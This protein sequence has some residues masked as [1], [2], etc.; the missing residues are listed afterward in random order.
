MKKLPIIA[1]VVLMSSLLALPALAKNAEEKPIEGIED[2]DRKQ[3][4]A[5]FEAQES[6]DLGNYYAAANAVRVF[7]E[8]EPG[9]DHYLL[10]FALASD[11]S[12]AEKD[13]DAA[14]NYKRCVELEPRFAQGWLNLGELAYNLEDYALAAEA[15]ENGYNLH[16]ERPPRLLYYAA[17]AHVLN[18]D[19][20]SAIPALEHLTSGQA[21]EPE[22]DWFRALV[23]AAIELDDSE[24]GERAI[25]NLLKAHGATA[26]A[27]Y[28]SFQYYASMTDY[29]AA[30]TSLTITG[31]L[32]PLTK[33]ELTQLGD[34]YSAIDV[35]SEASEYY[36][37]AFGDSATAVEAERLASAHLAA[38]DDEEAFETL[39]RELEEDPTPRLWSLLGD[40]HYMER[41][42][43]ESY[44]AFE[45]CASLDQ[46]KGRPYIMM[47]YCAIELE[48]YDDAIAQLKRA[49]E[50]ED[51][52][53]QAADLLM[54]VEAMKE[55]VN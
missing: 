26:D 10:R 7:L 53:E 51:Q 3:R 32:R 28:L 5:L 34:L 15:L 25:Q 9:R 37:L 2:L 29:R 36:T 33:S 54:R 18:E 41:Q 48:R 27:W 8:E 42:Y 40:L 24:V 14:E 43:E 35:P 20:A 55:A 6:R 22:L 17:V 21:G 52:A 1:I 11:L 46:S 30:A 45:Q 39:R 47:A 4:L 50:Y 49:S 12:S 16:E 13:E 23:M 44:K 19:P 38:H 31:Y